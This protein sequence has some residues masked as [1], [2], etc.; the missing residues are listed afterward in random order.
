MKVNVDKTK[1]TNAEK[2]KMHWTVQFVGP[3]DNK[4]RTHR[5]TYVVPIFKTTSAS[6]D[7]QTLMA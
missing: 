3:M 7:A 4:L 5:R 1:D 2:I 6:C